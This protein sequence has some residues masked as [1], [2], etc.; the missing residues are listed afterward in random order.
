MAFQSVQDLTLKLCYRISLTSNKS[1]NC[2]FF[3]LPPLLPSHKITSFS[4]LLRR[5]F[6]HKNPQERAYN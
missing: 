6:P 4:F 5:K 2:T 1:L 3:F